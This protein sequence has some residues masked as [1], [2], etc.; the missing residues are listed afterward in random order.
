M[1]NLTFLFV[2]LAAAALLLS[3]CATPPPQS[4]MQIRSYQTRTYDTDGWKPP[5]TKKDA[6]DAIMDALQDDGYVL[7]NV[8][9]DLGFI[10][11]SK[12]YTSINGQERV[13]K[14]CLAPCLNFFA[15]HSWVK[16]TRLEATANVQDEK[17]R[18][19]VRMSFQRTLVDSKDKTVS[20]EA[21]G[22]VVFYQD[23]FSRVDKS[24]FLKRNKL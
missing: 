22:D 14:T 13:L 7:K 15:A 23:F 20:V 12:E 19:K 5:P 10:S 18:L 16:T 1:K 17:D 6:L 8:A 9:T 24:L 4:T 2:F 11:A 21:L 3:G